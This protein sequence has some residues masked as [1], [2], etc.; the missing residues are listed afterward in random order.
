MS[1][2]SQREQRLVALF[3]LLLVVWAGWQ[4]VA[5]PVLD[6]FAERRRERAE[7][8]ATLERNQRLIAAIP[9]L[10]QRI[11]AQQVDRARFQL[12]AASRDTAADLLRQRLQAS[13]ERH[14]ASITNVGEGQAAARWAGA[15]AEGV[16]TLDQL[17]R[18]LAELHNQPPYLLITNMTV[19]ADRAFQ[20]RQLEP[21]NVRI[22]V[23]IPYSQ[24][25]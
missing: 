9:R 19:T 10:R 3:L 1:G 4:F 11:E 14:G 13:F 18:V 24:T 12:A 2:L 25:A 17:V 23:A 15:S 20:T 5:A 7:L 22:D 6:G 21:M 8:V 16:M